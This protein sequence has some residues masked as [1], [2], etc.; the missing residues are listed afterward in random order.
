MQTETGG[1]LPRYFDDKELSELLTMGKRG[2]CEIKERLPQSKVD[3]TNHIFGSH[4]MVHCITPHEAV[5]RNFSNR[6][7]G[8][9]AAV[10]RKRT[11]DEIMEADGA[12]GSAPVVTEEPRKFIARMVSEAESS[13]VTPEKA[14]EEGI[15]I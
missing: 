14:P 8:K 13:V 7:A 2:A 9:R 12:D 3:P 11:A 5:Y 4:A 6:F 10:A 1:C 15:D